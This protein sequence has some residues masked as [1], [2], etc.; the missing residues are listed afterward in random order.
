MSCQPKGYEQQNNTWRKPA[1]TS[2]WE[3]WGGGLFIVALSLI[4]AYKISDFWRDDQK[5]EPQNRWEQMR[6]NDG[7]FWKGTPDNSAYADM[8][9]AELR[10]YFQ[11]FYDSEGR[12]SKVNTFRHHDYYEDV[13]VLSNEETYEYDSQGRVSRRYDAQGYTRIYEYTR[14]GCTETLSS[15]SHANETTARYNLAGNQIYFRNA[16]NYRY[17]HA[18]TSEYD[19][20]NRLVRKILEVEGRAPYGIPPH[21]I[22]SIEYN[23]EN[24]TSVETEYDSDGEITYVWFNTYDKE[25]NKTESVW[26]EP[27]KVPEGYSPEECADYYTKGYWISYSDGRVMEEMEN[28]PWKKNSSHNDSEYTAYDYD[29]NGN[30]IMMLKVYRVGYAYLYRYVY[31]SRNRMTE[32]YSYNIDDVT[33]WEQLQSDGSM[34]TLKVFDEENLSITRTARDGALLNRFVYGAKD[35]SI[36]QTPEATVRWQLNPALILAEK[37]P[38]PAEIQPDGTKPAAPGETKPEQPDI[39]SS[40][41]KFFYIVKEGDCLWSIAEEFLGD[42]R[43]YRNICMWNSDVIGNDPWLILPGI[44]LYIEIR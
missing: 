37:G 8:E 6:G 24:Y 43:K 23:E 2:R 1:K 4:F 42:G 3:K 28:A 9:G 39:P 29:G 12:L 26:Y 5:A 18:T 30:C 27:E 36:Q 10:E 25:W 21:V 38:K 22:L 33:F 16:V 7:K 41:Q 35:V 44:R 11:Y 40:P 17:P 13:W 14:D 19:D 34:L 15:S 20:K 31:D 32:Q